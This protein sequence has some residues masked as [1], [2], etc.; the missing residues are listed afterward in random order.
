MLTKN[1]EVVQRFVGIIHVRDTTAR[2]LKEAIY[3]FLSDHSLSPSQIRGEGYDGA[4]KMQGELNSLKAW[5]LNE[6]SS[7]YCIDC[8]A[9]QLLLTLVALAKK[10][11]NVDNFFLLSY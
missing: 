1:S 4:S 9:H 2:L 3:S 5:I 6:T 11:S 10:D 7:A 8:F